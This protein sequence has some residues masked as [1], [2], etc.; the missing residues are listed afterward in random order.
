M[1]SNGF[2]HDVRRPV[3]PNAL[4]VHFERAQRFRAR[5]I[6]VRLASRLAR[7]IRKDGVAARQRPLARL[8]LSA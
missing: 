4:S 1:K 2:Q 5:F 6:A 3:A 7:R 8:V